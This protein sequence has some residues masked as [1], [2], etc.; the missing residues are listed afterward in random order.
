M[1]ANKAEIARIFGVSPP[2]VYSRVAGI[3]Q[4]IGKRY[5]P[6]AILENLVSIEVYADYE[7]YHK[8]LNHRNLRKTVPPFSMAEAREYLVEEGLLHVVCS[9]A[10]VGR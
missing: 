5:N 2:T 3:Q 8:R 1:Y 9:K 4:E 10:A 6:Y 7:K